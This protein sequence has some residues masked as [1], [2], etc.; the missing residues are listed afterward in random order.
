MLTDL[1]GSQSRNFGLILFI[2]TCVTS[3]SVTEEVAAS[4]AV[5][6]STAELVLGPEQEDTWTVD[7]VEAA[8]GTFLSKPC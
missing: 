8:A 6:L 5:G 1:W 2:L 4:G 3:L 7:G